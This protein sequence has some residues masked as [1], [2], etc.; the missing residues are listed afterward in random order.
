MT[1]G[2]LA[3]PCSGD[4]TQA[5]QHRRR[6]GVREILATGMTVHGTPCA[7]HS[8][9]LSLL[10]PISPRGNFQLHDKW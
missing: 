7:V 2:G 5:N 8:V 10:P 6:G 1:G 9:D 3:T 4:W